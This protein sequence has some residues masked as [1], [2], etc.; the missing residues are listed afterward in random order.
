MPEC[1]FCEEENPE[2]ALEC[3]N[4]HK[5]PFSGMYLEN[6]FFENINELVKS[7]NVDPA[8][9]KLLEEYE[10]HTDIDYYDDETAMKIVDELQSIFEKYPEAFKHRFELSIIIIE[11]GRFWQYPVH[12][13]VDVA[14]KI[15]SNFG[16]EKMENR[17]A[18]AVDYYNH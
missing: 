7:R 17:L 16:D 8:C 6:G 3:F 15:V 5:K 4:C 2:D 11:R 9:E 14:R 18:E 12:E 13:E 10:N 1:I